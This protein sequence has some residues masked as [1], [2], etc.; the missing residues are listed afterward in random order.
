MVKNLFLVRHAEAAEANANQ[1]DFERELTPKGY[2]DAPRVGRYL[3]EKQFQ[4]NIIWSSNAQRA[5]A[6]SEL[7][8]EQL[9]FDP[10][11]IKTSE[12]IYHASV[13]SLLQLITEQKNSHDQVLVVGHNPAM[14]YL[15]EY[16]TG[17][18]IGDMLPCSVVHI[19][20]DVEHW[21]EVSQDSGN[22]EAYLIPDNLI[23]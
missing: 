3:F 1:R 22:L 6:T 12:D 15:A 18:E 9:K 21:M 2:R 19:T 14:T 8:A 5:I 23:L 11:R 16:L 4:P 13:R 20:F 7:M 17:E 10:H